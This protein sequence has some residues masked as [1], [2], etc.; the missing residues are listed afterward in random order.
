LTYGPVSGAHFNPAVTLADASQGGIA[1]SQV[2]WHL[3][4][5]LSGAFGGVA[6]AHVMFAQPALFFPSQR[7]RS[8]VARC[9]ACHEAR[10]S[11]VGAIATEHAR[12]IRA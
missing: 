6:V 5:Q 2:P 4:A 3:L 12:R 9:L 8:G 10:V 7:E 1:W 11:S